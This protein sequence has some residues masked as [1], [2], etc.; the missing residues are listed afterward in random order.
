MLLRGI[1]AK[2]VTHIYAVKSIEK[3]VTYPNITIQPKIIGYFVVW[4]YYINYLC[5]SRRIK[6][7]NRKIIAYK[8]YFNIFFAELDKGTQNKVLYVLMLLRTQDRLPTKFIK[9]I[10]DGLFEVRIE[11]NSNIY[12][13]FFIFDGNK[14]VVLFN[15]FQK[16][17]QKTP[18]NE[19]K[20]A[21]KLKEEY[22]ASKGD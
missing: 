2:N 22:Y 15:G 21:I 20:R 8:E 13:I 6:P 7:M 4:Y 14:I 19:I 1:K 16:K 3:A 5:N 10:R 17:T 12:R 18:V 9:A 11:Y